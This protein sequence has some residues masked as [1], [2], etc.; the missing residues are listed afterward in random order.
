MEKWFARKRKSETLELT[1]R[2]MTLP[3][4]VRGVRVAT[5][6]RRERNARAKKRL[7]A[8]PDHAFSRTRSITI[9]SVPDSEYSIENSRIP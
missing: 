6:N 1:D 8:I 4:D 7:H 2:Q 5:R 3:I 9:H